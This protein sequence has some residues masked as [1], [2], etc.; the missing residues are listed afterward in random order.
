MSDKTNFLF[1]V[2]LI[3]KYSSEVMGVYSTKEKAD[4]ALARAPESDMGADVS[5]IVVDA[6]WNG[7]DRHGTMELVRDDNGDLICKE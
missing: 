3:H 7:N 5:E 4:A 6:D 1:M 2:T